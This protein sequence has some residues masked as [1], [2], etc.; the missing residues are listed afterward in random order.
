MAIGGS[1]LVPDKQARQKP[2]LRCGY[3]LRSIVSAKNCPECGLA[4]RIS[5]SDNRALEWTNPSWQRGL[6][7]GFGVLALGMTFRALDGAAGLLLDGADE[8]W[9]SMSTAMY[10]SLSWASTIAIDAA[11]IACGIGLC[12]LARGERRYPD[13]SRGA[14]RVAFIA[15][16][17]VLVLGITR[18]CVKYRLFG[19][20]PQWAYFVLWRTVLA[21]PWLALILSVLACSYALDLAK[22][23][24]SRTLA[25]MSQWPIWPV[26]G[27]FVMWLFNLHRLWWP[28]RVIVWDLIFPLSMIAMLIVT[29]LVLLRGAREA[30]LNWVTDPEW[31]IDPS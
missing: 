7:V 8:E 5:L 20:L 21:G 17:I 11:P 6:A 25:R 30:Q 4:A 26:A 18:T 14:R 31:K 29:I 19:T 28:L 27:G 3:S 9:F 23:G 12:L 10:T 2:C 16:A 1:I 22:R 13:G 24:R 15:G